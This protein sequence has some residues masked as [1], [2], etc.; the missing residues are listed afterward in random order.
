MTFPDERILRLDVW[1]G[2]EL[3]QMIHV[4]KN[5]LPYFRYVGWFFRC[6]EGLTYDGLAMKGTYYDIHPNVYR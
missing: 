4:L 5:A 6:W 2:V 3:Q 1:N